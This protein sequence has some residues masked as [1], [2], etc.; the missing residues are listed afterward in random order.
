M[1]QSTYIPQSKRYVPICSFWLNRVF[2]H[3]ANS[4]EKHCLTIDCSYKNQNGPAQYR[5]ATDNPDQQV[6]Y[7]NKPNDDKYY[8]V[9]IRKRIKPEYFS[10]GI[11][12]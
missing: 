2:T 11:Y 1:L 9:S 12:F 6:C 10:D 3:L 8:D 7:F 4:H 5:S